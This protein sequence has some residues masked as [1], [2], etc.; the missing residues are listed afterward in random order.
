MMQ[1]PPFAVPLSPSLRYS[2]RRGAASTSAAS[3]AQETAAAEAAAASKSC[4]TKVYR[5]VDKATCTGT[6]SSR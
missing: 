5:T 2:D 1:R 4:T 6:G 3:H